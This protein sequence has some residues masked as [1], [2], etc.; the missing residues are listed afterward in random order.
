MFLII[1]VPTV[2][3]ASTCGRRLRSSSGRSVE[4]LGFLGIIGNGLWDLTWFLEMI[5]ETNYW[6][7]L[8]MVI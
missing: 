1:R 3:A 2:Q 6:Y 5:I 7:I 8:Q 4:I